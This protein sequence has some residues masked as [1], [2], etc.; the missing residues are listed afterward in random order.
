MHTCACMRARVPVFMVL[1]LSV[2]FMCSDTSVLNACQ[3]IHLLV[4]AVRHVRLICARV[5]W[6]VCLSRFPLVANVSFLLLFFFELQGE[7][8]G[9]LKKNTFAKYPDDIIHQTV[10]FIWI[11]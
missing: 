4:S 11:I 5:C 9:T 1:H 3:G 10:C 8:N 2:V 6:R 7:K